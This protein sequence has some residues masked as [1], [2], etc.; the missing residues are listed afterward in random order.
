MNTD[1]QDEFEQLTRSLMAATL[2]ANDEFE[3]ARLDHAA[4]TAMRLAELACSEDIDNDADSDFDAAH[5][6]LSSNEYCPEWANIHVAGK[7]LRLIHLH[8]DQAR[9]RRLAAEKAQRHAA[10]QQ[11]SVIR[12][13][14]VRVARP[15]RSWALRLVRP[16]W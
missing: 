2:H 1:R 3:A 5:R 16:R 13:A 15:R 8:A 4:T 6:L 10:R 12:A 11:A 9:D 7:H 14:E